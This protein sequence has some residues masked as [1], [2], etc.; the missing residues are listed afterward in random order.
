[1]PDGRECDV[2]NVRMEQHLQAVIRQQGATDR[3]AKPPDW[4]SQIV[5]SVLGPLPVSP[6]LPPVDPAALPLNLIQR[7]K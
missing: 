7:Q 4:L 1:M 3:M 2:V 5:A 6:P